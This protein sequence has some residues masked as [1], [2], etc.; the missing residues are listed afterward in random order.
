MI[1]LLRFFL[2][3]LI[4]LLAFI[5]S[6]SITVTKMSLYSKY[7]N[8]FNLLNI[9]SSCSHVKSYENEICEIAYYEKCSDLIVKIKYVSRLSCCHIYHQN[10]TSF[11]YVNLT[12]LF[13]KNKLRLKTRTFQLVRMTL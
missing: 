6:S 3:T 9:N 5:F 8:N 4:S 2:L 13:V 11:I 12:L 7:N 10:V 1:L